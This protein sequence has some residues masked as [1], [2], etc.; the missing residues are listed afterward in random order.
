MKKVSL[1]FYICF[2]AFTS[3]AHAQDK[4][5]N[6]QTELKRLYDIE[7][8]PR[9]ISGSN[10]WEKSSYDTTGGNDDGF[11]G[12]YSFVRR[13]PDSTLVI[14]EAKGKGVINRIW[15]PTR[16]DDTLDFYFDGK[17]KP[18]FSIK[19]SDL[20]SDK[21]FPFI[22]PLC[23]NQLGGYYCYL[24]MP[25][26]NGCKIVLRAKQM[27]FYQIQC[28]SYPDNYSVKTFN[29]QL[30]NNEKNDLKK[31]AALWGTGNK[32]VTDFYNG[33]VEVANTSATIKPGETLNLLKLN[34]GGRIVGIE[35]SPA[36][37]FVGVNKLIDLKVTW[38]GE[39]NPAIY[40]P[41]AD[42]FG[43]AFGNPS[44]QSLLLGTEKDKNYCYFPMPFDKKARI[45]LIYRTPDNGIPATDKTIQ[46]KVY[47]S[48]VKRDQLNEGKFYT[49]WFND[50][51]P[52]VGKPHVFL[53]ANGKGHYVGTIL[54]AQGLNAGM[55]LFFEGDDST[56]TDGITR[57]HGTGSEDYF[58]GGW[59]AL[60]DRWDT[61]MSLPLHGALDYSLPFARTGGYRLYLDDKISFNNHIFHSIEHGPQGN[62]VPVDYTSVALYYSSDPVS[63]I[64]Q[65]INRLSRSYVLDTLIMYPQLMKFGF[66]GITGVKEDYSG[67]NFTADDDGRINIS[68]AAIPPGRYKLYAD[69]EINPKG[70]DISFWQRQTQVSGWLSLNSPKKENKKQMYVCDLTIG[71]FKNSISIVFKTN[72]ENNELMLKRLIFTKE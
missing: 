65:P 44:M 62:K 14:F 69:V 4:K 58:N 42:F 23:G 16:D 28:R 3:L 52:A 39:K 25:F 1:C 67:F 48:L 64:N 9:Y 59:Y 17:E 32:A 71:E 13:N 68:L 40:A 29:P 11:S 8:L 61:K 2:L 49:C 6:L 43:Y 55:T 72:G 30:S 45:D 63:K 24:P 21:V 70:A 66:W 57:I 27:Q 34:N 47:Y 22:H 60:M 35:I 15:M 5:V 19:F 36:S 26:N 41:L 37:A 54:Q 31:I 18:A 33:Q 56:S 20:F 50:M 38:D 7:Q 10:E 51:K 53:N 12:R 46:V